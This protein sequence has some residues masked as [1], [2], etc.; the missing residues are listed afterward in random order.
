M[1]TMAN[2]EVYDPGEM[3]QKEVYLLSIS[4]CFV[5]VFLM[6]FYSRE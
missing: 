3:P 2:S 5:V 1:G 4:N 6:F